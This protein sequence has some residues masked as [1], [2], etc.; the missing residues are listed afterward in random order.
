MKNRLWVFIVLRS[1]SKFNMQYVCP[2]CD[3]ST[4]DRAFVAIYV[5]APT[6]KH[7]FPRRIFTGMN[8]WKNS[9]NML[10]SI[11]STPWIRMPQRLT[12]HHG[13]PPCHFSGRSEPLNV[14]VNDWKGRETLEGGHVVC[15]NVARTQ[16]AVFGRDSWNW[17]FFRFSSAQS[18]FFS[19]TIR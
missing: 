9:I 1:Q 8:V 15:R 7:K 13:R 6:T 14:H 4:S 12:K 19:T 5:R 18:L 16:K 2:C 17:I 3:W 11:T 10:F